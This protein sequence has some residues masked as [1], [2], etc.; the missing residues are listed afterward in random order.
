MGKTKKSNY[1]RKYKRR[2]AYT[3]S[4]LTS[5]SSPKCP[6]PNKFLFKT[7]YFQK[8][9]SIN[10]GTGGLCDSYVFSAN[11]LWDPDISGLSG[12]SVIGFDQLMQMYD[13]YTVLGSRIRVTFHNSSATSKLLCGVYLN[14]EL[15]EEPDSQKIIENG[16]GKYSYLLEEGANPSSAKQI[17]CN[18]SAKKFFSVKDPTDRDSLKGD[19]GNNPTEQAYYHIWACD[20]DTADPGAVNLLVEVEYIALLTEP[21][22]LAIS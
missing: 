14:D 19:V 13:H 12:H 10:P 3:N 2:S 15:T 18:F 4:S 8:N 21:Q 17:T 7:R 11:G 1:K 22:Q 6:L 9:I 5:Y 16:L 20:I